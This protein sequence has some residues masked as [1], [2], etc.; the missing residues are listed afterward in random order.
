[1]NFFRLKA[2]QDVAKYYPN[3]IGIPKPAGRYY[4]EFLI[5]GKDIPNA[6]FT[7]INALLLHHV[8]L[9]TIKSNIDEDRKEFSLTLLCDFEDSDL[10]AKDLAAQIQDMNFV[11]ALELFEMSG[12]MFGR[13]YPLTFYDEHR[14]VALRSSTLIK[15]AMRLAEQVGALGTSLLYEEGRAYAKEVTRELKELLTKGES[16]ETRFYD[17]GTPG[18]RSVVEAYCLKCKTMR[19]IR[20]SHQVILGNKKPATQGICPVCGT[21]MFKMGFRAFN[22]IGAKLLIENLQGFLLAAGWGTFEL[23]S[24][25]KGRQGNVTVLDPPTLDSDVS[26]GNQF[27]EGIAAGFLEAITGT[28]NEVK[29]VGEKYDPQRRILS[30]R[31]TELVPV[32]PKLTSSKKKQTMKTKRRKYERRTPKQESKD[33]P[34][35]ADNLEADEVERIIQSLKKIESESREPI[36]QETALRQEPQE[37]VV[38]DTEHNH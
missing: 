30:L 10:A 24:E 18:I 6:P 22:T 12:R 35:P 9:L 34:I 13:S 29:L 21:K 28:N 15:L 5:M 19:E 26:Y 17:N 4:Y 2:Q 14:A 3:N 32:P 31:F 36:Q 1:M 25:I 27:V 37:I 7:V 38:Q 11:T 8:R 16:Q 20:D 33:S 23:R